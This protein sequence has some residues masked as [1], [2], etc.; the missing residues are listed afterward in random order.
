MPELIAKTALSGQAPV[1]HADTTLAEAD[2]GQITGIACFPG[3]MA[4]VK[5]ALGGFPGPNCHADGLVWTGPEQAFLI[6]RPAPDLGGL[7]AV[8]DQSGGWAALSLKGP[9]APEALMRLVP[10]DLRHFG[11][12][13]AARAPLGHMQ[14]V[15]L[16]QEDGF[17]ILIFRSMART[18]WHEIETALK[19]LAARKAL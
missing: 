15:L 16:G 18:A 9:M 11:A 3:Q 7:A 8:T 12:G 17:V 10:L 6:G 5:T 13:Q 2:L 14:S 4:K 19:M 1:T